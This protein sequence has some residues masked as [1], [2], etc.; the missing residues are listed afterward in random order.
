MHAIRT[1]R[2]LA[3]VPLCLA[4]WACSP[5]GP[6]DHLADARKSMADK[7]YKTALVQLKSALQADPQLAEARL[8]LG[9]VLLEGGQP[10]EA[11]VELA[12]AQEA[13][14]P[15]E[16]VAPLHA[17][18]LLR[19]QQPR[20]VIER[21]KDVKLAEPRAQA[22]L[23]TTLALAHFGERETQ[24]GRQALEEALAAD[25]KFA[26]ALVL[27][28]RLMGVEGKVDEALALVQ[29]AQAAQPDLAEA[30]VVQGHL[31]LAQQ[32]G[33]AAATQAFEAALKADPPNVEAHAMLVRLA[34]QQ[35]DAA[36]M[37]KRLEALRTQVPRHPQT[38]LF[39]AQLAGAEGRRDEA[40]QKLDQLLRI[41]PDN[42]EVLLSAAR[43]EMQQGS[44]TLAE[45][46]L[47]KA[48]SLAPG[49]ASARVM[50]AQAHLN[51]G[52]A[53]KA[54][55]TL[56]P[57]VQQDKP[58]AEPLALAAYAHMLEGRLETAQQLFTRAAKL[59][60][61]NTRIRTA[62]ALL[63]M[64][65]GE[66]EQG[67]AELAATAESDP[68]AFADL[69]LFNATLRRG[70]HAGALK[71]IDRVETK[72]P[73]SPMVPM[74]RASVQ[75]RMNDRAG[76]RAS[77]EKALAMDPSFFPATVALAELD[78]KDGRADEAVRRFDAL[79]AQ[80]PGHARA[81]L[82]RAQTR[83]LAGMP[84]AQVRSDIE[85]AVR[86]NPKDPVPKVALVEHLLAARQAAA[87]LT[88][89]QAAAAALPDEPRVLEVLARAQLAAGEHRQAESTYR[90]LT[91]AQPRSPAPW[92]GLAQVALAQS[93]RSTAVKMLRKA[94]ELQ[95]GDLEATRRLFELQVA[96]GAWNDA[97][98]TSRTLQKLQP[99]R[100]EG[101][102]LEGKVHAGRKQW[103]AAVN[104]YR[105]A[106]RAAPDLARPTLELHAALQAAGQRAEAD[107]V[108]EQWF[109]AHPDDV[110]LRMALADTALAR[111][112]LAVAEPLYREV[113]GI[114]PRHA[115]ALN[116]LAWVMAR[117]GKPGSAEI[118]ERAHR[119]APQNAVILDT[120][121][122]A[123]A[124]ENKLPQA[125]ETQKKALALAPEDP[126]M[127]LALAR[128]AVKAG[129][130]ALARAELDKLAALGGK[131]RGQD[132][133]RKLQQS[134]K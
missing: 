70:D 91:N 116:N 118:A 23:R 100:P 56:A 55:A 81:L 39:E 54:L 74:L 89:A 3:L 134:L 73:R 97:L 30:W 107:R 78:V 71:I 47:A 29:Q 65:R 22:D 113:S 11:A 69:A 109:K 8:L 75:L 34:S 38:A 77:H 67:L 13:G 27:K 85:E 20:R 129:D 111:G 63:K 79:L 128:M 14:L 53:D 127:R 120:W 132:E 95:P 57:L 50:L 42:L 9:T 51:G 66:S 43:L 12:K 19:A 88:S 59:Q 36:L 123:L 64:S 58:Q 87:A 32:G 76:A 60:P 130:T 101:H 83:R 92:V 90:K 133:V 110:T 115:V 24:P 18:A 52:Q 99:G 125:L 126:A 68:T 62:L 105:Q 40:R 131:F 7:D 104:A 46:H 103:P 119:L 6:A 82:A 106:V 114:D 41:A 102:L 84:E 86:L 28:A 112:E 17:K 15:A 93:D 31:L 2:A 10:A 16:R 49:L 48:L 94:L 72:Q 98:Q 96:A 122:M 37:K 5:Q 21:F 61:E 121:A 1:P 33:G 45:G 44:L 4:L 35:Q 108:R 124:A 26:P 25:A 80:K 117:Q